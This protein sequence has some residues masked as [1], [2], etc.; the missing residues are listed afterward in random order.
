MC[1]PV[2]IAKFLRTPILK[3]IFERLLFM[4]V[5]DITPI[6]N[7]FSSLQMRFPFFFLITAL[8]TE[9]SLIAKFTFA[10]DIA[11]ITNIAHI[12]GITR[13]NAIVII[14][15]KTLF[16]KRLSLLLLTLPASLT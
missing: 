5:V 7:I 16:L 13:I 10:T 4:L 1:F 6:T 12:T 8:V 3:N 15:E 11:H 14:T 9:I 2:N